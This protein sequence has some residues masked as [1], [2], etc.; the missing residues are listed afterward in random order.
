MKTLF[1]ALLAVCA[2]CLTTGVNAGVIVGDKEWR[3]V[4]AT[5][6]FSW[7][8]FASVCDETTGACSSG[9]LNNSTVGTVSF[10]GWTWASQGNVVGLF[11]SLPGWDGPSSTSFF[12]HGS[13]DSTWGPAFYSLGFEPTYYAHVNIG[14]FGETQSFLTHGI[15]RTTAPPDEVFAPELRFYIR[16]DETEAEFFPSTS[17]P[18]SIDGVSLGGWFYRDV[19]V[20]APPTLALLLVPALSMVAVRRKRFSH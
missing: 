4:T 16:P 1:K 8:D 7:N 11:Q 10:D 19:A 2:V 5:S 17:F 12:R 18:A 14:L 20:P 13:I 15:T 9:T 3:Q 6:G